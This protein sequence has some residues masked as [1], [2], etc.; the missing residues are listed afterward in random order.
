MAQ[1]QR[2]HD[3]AATMPPNQGKL[4]KG[5]MPPPTITSR[6]VINGQP[7][8]PPGLQHDNAG[9]TN[10]NNAGQVENETKVYP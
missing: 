9:K 1:R 7:Q 4:Q 2:H 6:G 8:P 5:E 10:Q 3:Q